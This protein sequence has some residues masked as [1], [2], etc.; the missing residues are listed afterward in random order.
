MILVVDNGSCHT[1]TVTR[2]ALA[3]RAAW[4]EVVPLS[5]YRPDRNLKER[6]WRPLKRDHRSHLTPT[7]GAFVEVLIG[8]LRQLGGE[9]FDI[10][11]AVPDWWLAGHRK[12]PT[13]RPAGRP[14][15]AMDSRPR[16]RRD[17]KLPA[18]S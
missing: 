8:G 17:A 12:E 13:G 10:V 2:Q 14:T 7:L 4:L 6:E 16:Q 9:R 18:P 1:S 15:G 3:E 11:A 5:R